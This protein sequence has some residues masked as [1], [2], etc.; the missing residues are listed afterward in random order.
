MSAEILEIVVVGGVTYAVLGRGT[1]PT[2]AVPG[3]DTIYTSPNSGATTQDIITGNAGATP[4]LA[5]AATA[6]SAAAAAVSSGQAH[7]MSRAALAATLAN[8]AYTAP[9]SFDDHATRAAGGT[10][11]ATGSTPDMQAKL[12]AVQ[13]YCNQQFDNMSAVE[14]GNAASYLNDQLK[15]DP[16]LTGHESWEQVASIAGGAAGAAAGTAICGPICGKIGALA[17]AY[18]GAKLEDLLS[19]KLDDLKGWLNDKVWGA[20]KDAANKVEDAVKDAANAAGD[21]AEDAYNA[22]GDYISGI[23]PF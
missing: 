17:G 23:N 11:A 4:T 13:A 14:K 2:A 18:L 6:Q 15:L 22:A 10:P 16:P 21:A 8:R 3:G 9:G 12:D 7:G 1:D 20:I 19:K 5:T